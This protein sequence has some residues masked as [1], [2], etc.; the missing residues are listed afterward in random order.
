MCF[1][2]A[3]NEGEGG[4]LALLS[5]LQRRRVSKRTLT[6][7][8]T[9]GIFGTALFFGDSMITPAISVLS[10]VEGLAVVDAGLHDAVV[11][12]AVAILVVLLLLQRSAL[13]GSA[14]CSAR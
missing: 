13:G 11:P 2:G 1:M 10:S 6:M 3:D 9:L 5:L 14:N 8:L 7:L 12:G 4:L